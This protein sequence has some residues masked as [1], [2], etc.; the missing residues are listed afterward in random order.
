MLLVQGQHFD[1]YMGRDSF[2]R[3]LSMW[4]RKEKTSERKIEGVLKKSLRK[5]LSI[6]EGKIRR[7]EGSMKIEPKKNV[8]RERALRAETSRGEGIS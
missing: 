1:Y 6:S 8:L 3:K 7:E 4:K 2:V 5:G